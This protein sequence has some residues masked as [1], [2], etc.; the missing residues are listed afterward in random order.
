MNMSP[1]RR[2]VAEAIAAAGTI[3]VNLPEA[4]ADDI[5]VTRRSVEN[6]LRA[7]E[8]AGA[9]TWHRKQPFGERRPFWI[10]DVTPDHWLW[11]LDV[12]AA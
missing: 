2:R 11:N 12:E 1:T 5:G 7:L 6:A 9:I 10:V 3:H 8:K 4:L